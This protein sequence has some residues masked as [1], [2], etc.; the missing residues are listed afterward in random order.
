VPVIAGGF[1]S[2]DE[3]TLKR[4]VDCSAAACAVWLKGIEVS[5]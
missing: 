3:T 1:R 4:I 5:H 2:L